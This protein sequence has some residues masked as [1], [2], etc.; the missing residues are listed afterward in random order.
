MMQPLRLP[1]LVLLFGAGCSAKAENPGHAQ[2]IAPASS[3]STDGVAPIAPVASK[4]V[5]SA[6]AQPEAALAP[7]RK[8]LIDSF[9]ARDILSLSPEAMS[10]RFAELHA[11]KRERETI[12]GFALLGGN[13]NERLFFDYAPNGKSGFSC[14]LAKL[15]FQMPDA[16]RASELEDSIEQQLHTSLGKPR[17]YASGSG[18]RYWKL[19]RHAEASLSQY[20]SPTT[21]GTFVVELSVS[22]PGGP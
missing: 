10:A 15:T 3:V 13:A 1:V 6:P 19:G 7:A 20:G 9:V 22:E 11:L 4:P 2:T 5:P 8:K 14:Q 17:K 21:P 12:D 18:T 16:E